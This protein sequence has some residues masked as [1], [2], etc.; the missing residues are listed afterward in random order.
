MS[1]KNFELSFFCLSFI[2]LFIFFFYA[3]PLV[4][5]DGDD[6]ALLSS[7]RHG[8]PIWGAWN[9]SKVLPAVIMPLC[10]LLSAYIFRPLLGDYITAVTFCS[11][12]ILS[13]TIT[14]YLWFFYR[15][16]EKKF[17]LPC[18]ECLMIT[19]L[20]LSCHFVVFASKNSTIHLFSSFNLTCCFYYVLPALVNATL[21]L[22]L[23]TFYNF[24]VETNI[25]QNGF[26][27]LAVY[28]AIFSNIF[29]SIILSTFI[30]VQLIFFYLEESHKTLNLQHIKRFIQNNA[31]WFVIL[32]IWLVSLLFEANGGR[33]NQIGY[34][35]VSLPIKAT[36]VSL[37]YLLKQTYKGFGI[38]FLIVVC[39]AGIS[40]I[41]C[42]NKQSKELIYRNGVI[43]F[44]ICSVS[45]LSYEILVCAKAVPS[46]IANGNVVFSFLFYLFLLLCFSLSFLLCKHSK[47]IPVLPLLC[48]IV[49]IF[50][51]NNDTR[52]IESTYRNTAPNKCVLVDK[53][54]IEQIV[55]ADRAGKKEMVLT[56]PKS[57]TKDNY[58][59]PN[60]LGRNISRTLYKHGI[61]YGNIKIT[62][63]PDVKMNLKY[64]LGY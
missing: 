28:L 4:L 2:G 40:Y 27:V 6:W 39:L 46:Y 48:F 34:S 22:Y 47:V 9:P 12:L 11:S 32:I 56:V 26:L 64:R 57:N 52:F 3:H 37:G 10:G 30:L 29:H 8:Y 43:K 60:Y 1:K 42:K 36:L 62:V 38:T 41:K 54:L 51:F 14:M 58:P 24:L 19:F 44:A 45:I 31:S 5:F 16:I 63:K 25:K 18:A 55:K 13:L 15:L 33:A 17:E 23:L 61:I 20:F 50:V 59:H 49:G 21:V 53:D 7:F 35:I